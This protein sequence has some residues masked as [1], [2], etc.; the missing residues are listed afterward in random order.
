MT[1]RLQKQDLTNPL[2][3]R[4]GSLGNLEVV[5]QRSLWIQVLKVHGDYRVFCSAH[6]LP[7]FQV[8]EAVH[9]PAVFSGRFSKLRCY[10]FSFL[11]KTV[12]GFPYPHLPGL[13]TLK[14]HKSSFLTLL[15]GDR[16]FKNKLLMLPL[17]L[18]YEG[19]QT[20]KQVCPDRV[21]NLHLR[22]SKLS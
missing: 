21:W 15:F 12:L 4:A 18:Y 17:H 19:D 5:L 20:M 1:S 6:L 8:F 10:F 11:P 7:S 9:I 16:K 2:A 13:R 22:W 14:S 3:R